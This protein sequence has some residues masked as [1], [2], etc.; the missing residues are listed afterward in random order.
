MST[1][2]KLNTASPYII[3]LIGFVVLYFIIGLAQTIWVAVP[4]TLAIIL[5]RSSEA[6]T[7]RE[8]LK[9]LASLH[10]D[11]PFIGVGRILGIL[12]FIV[13]LA[14]P[15]A[16]FIRYGWKAPLAYIIL[17]FVFG[18][19]FAF[20]GELIVTW[21]KLRGD[22]IA[23]ARES[24]KQLPDNIEIFLTSIM[25]ISPAF[26][27]RYEPYLQYVDENNLESSWVT[28]WEKY[29]EDVRDICALHLLCASIEHCD[30]LS[31]DT[32][33]SSYGASVLL[34]KS[35]LLLDQLVTLLVQKKKWNDI[36]T[37]NV[38]GLLAIACSDT[39]SKVP[40]PGG[41]KN[42]QVRGL[43]Y[44]GAAAYYRSDAETALKAW[45]RCDIIG[46]D[47]NEPTYQLCKQS[48]AKF[49]SGSNQ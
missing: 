9:F 46:K 49:F 26:K 19:V 47:S 17:S 18:I 37:F 28:E 8:R 41:I 36:Y 30:V 42:A 44:Q 6:I 33:V 25:R 40:V 4:L 5:N 43:Y 13:W 24:K 45:M 10:D 3:L 32:S 34:S 22:L 2:S 15:V 14:A 31:I 48:L 16:L 11:K 35:L 7:A 1:P 27:T 23:L 29:P 39:N 21:D 38:A 12:M 20:R